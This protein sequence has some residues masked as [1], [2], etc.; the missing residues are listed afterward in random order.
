M[1]GLGHSASRFPQPRRD[2]S[3]KSIDLKKWFLREDEAGFSGFRWCTILLNKAEC[4]FWSLGRKRES[5]VPGE[6]G[7][8]VVMLREAKGT[9][10]I[11]REY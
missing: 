11:R 3:S 2:G 8:T 1:M 4:R 6:I 9:L 7:A 10:K 5:I